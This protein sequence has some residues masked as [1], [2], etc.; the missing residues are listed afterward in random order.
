MSDLREALAAAIDDDDVATVDENLDTS[1]PAA[2][3]GEPAAA[4]EAS[5]ATE[6]TGT[7]RDA[8]GRFVPKSKAPEASD[9]APAAASPP[10]APDQSAVATAQPNEAGVAAPIQA[11]ASLSPLAR[12]HWAQVPPAVQAEVARREVEMQRFV[13]DTAQQRHI[14]DAF[15]QAVQP[16]QMAIQAEGVDP[17]TAVTNLMQIGSRLR[18]G[19][20]A[21]KANTVA[22]IIQ[23]YGVDI[24]AL[25]S[26]LAG[27]APQQ[28]QGAD[29]QYI[30]QLVQQQLAPI[31]Q[32]A[33]QRQQAAAQQIEVSTRAT[34][35][36][37]AADP[38]NEFYNDLRGTM[39]DMIEVAERQGY[40]LS[41]EE[42][43]Q[44]AAMLHPD[45][46]R[47]MLA[48]QQGV[49]A[50]KLTAAARTAKAAAVSVRGSAPVGNPNGAEPSSIRESIEAAIESHSRV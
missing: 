30:Q 36:Q 33:Q 19:T 24:Q 3:A 22:Q 18:F 48:R 1:A 32:A 17:I 6:D 7:V 39:A 25:D 23:A 45:V 5:D 35:Q 37:F 2:D 10:A 9:N 28:P 46:S 4:P 26:T 31:M 49:N 11:P 41:L 13:N 27:A 29:P 34:L 44:R 21:E 50:Q 12:E 20:P 40:Q 8:L 47:V 14:A 16:F 15:V 42:A 38:K 43:Y